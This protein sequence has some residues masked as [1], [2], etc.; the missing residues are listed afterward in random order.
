MLIV[1]KQSLQI[2]YK[3]SIF[4]VLNELMIIGVLES[5][6]HILKWFFTHVI[7]NLKCEHKRI[8]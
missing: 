5:I 3:P 8:S 2:P 1:Y 6:K 4:Q 7:G